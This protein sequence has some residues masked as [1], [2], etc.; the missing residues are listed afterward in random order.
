MWTFSKALLIHMNVAKYKPLK[1]SSYMELPKDLATKKAIVNVKNANNECFRWRVLSALY[2]Y[3]TK[4][5][6]RSLKRLTKINLSGD[7]GLAE[8]PMWGTGVFIVA[9]QG[10]LMLQHL[11]VDYNILLPLTSAGN[12]RGIEPDGRLSVHDVGFDPTRVATLPENTISRDS[13]GDYHFPETAIP[14]AAWRCNEQW[15]CTL[16]SL[17]QAIEAHNVRGFVMFQPGNPGQL[18][19]LF[20]SIGRSCGRGR[21]ARSPPFPTTNEYGICASSRSTGTNQLTDKGK[22][23]TIACIDGEVRI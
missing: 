17:G 16:A 3:D 19:F 13:D 5:P 9:G 21:G 14:I 2:D 12:V 23:N 15:P 10:Q 7:A 6:D 11:I 8:P 18:I 1:G 4:H 22:R 20:L